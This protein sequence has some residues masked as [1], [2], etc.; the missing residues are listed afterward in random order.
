MNSSR[1]FNWNP[2]ANE[3]ERNCPD[4]GA[5]G[6]RGGKR[7]GVF[8]IGDGSRLGAGG[9]DAAAGW[10][11]AVVGSRVGAGGTGRLGGGSR[12]WHQC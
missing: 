11:P 3:H 5:N 7:G 6:K 1:G 4:K 2:L 12:L 8:G 9:G 10:T